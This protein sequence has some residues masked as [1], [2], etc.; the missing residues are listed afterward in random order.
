MT[1]EWMYYQINKSFMGS[2]Y[3]CSIHFGS[4][5]NYVLLYFLFNKSKQD[6]QSNNVINITYVNMNKLKHMNTLKDYL[7]CF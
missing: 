4:I 5:C 2:K 7:T 3:I 6:F 1:Y